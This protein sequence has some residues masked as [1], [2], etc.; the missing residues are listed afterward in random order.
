MI[1]DMVRVARV[2]SRKMKLRLGTMAMAASGSERFT[3]AR[4]WMAA[5]LSPAKITNTVL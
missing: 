2:V 5:C 4:A 1:E 3:S